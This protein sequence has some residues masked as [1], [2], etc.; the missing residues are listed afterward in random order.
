MGRCRPPTTSPRHAV[1]VKRSLDLGHP[2]SLKKNRP[3]ALGAFK[4]P[5]DALYG[6]SVAELF[7][8]PYEE[9]RRGRTVPATRNEI[10][11]DLHRFFDLPVLVHRQS[12]VLFGGLGA[13][14]ISESLVSLDRLAQRLDGRQQHAAFE[15][16]QAT[17]LDCLRSAPMGIGI[18]SE[19]IVGHGRRQIV[20]GIV[21]HRA[22]R[23]N[24]DREENNCA[25]ITKTKGVQTAYFDL[26]RDTY[27]PMMSVLDLPGVRL[28]IRYCSVSNLA[29]P[30]F[31]FR[32]ISSAEAV[33]TKG[34][35]FLLLCF[36]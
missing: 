17:P 10:L 18:A 23:L 31:T 24:V 9:V 1:S 19:D 15:V 5:E 11:P 28:A 8:V 21:L 22:E 4:L 13:A 6:L 32:M 35:G 25:M 29:L 20:L 33:H 7:V 2:R 27:P 26:S 3:L 16:L 14:R 30:R 36:T 34:S 12:H